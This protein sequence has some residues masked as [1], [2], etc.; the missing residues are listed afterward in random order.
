MPGPQEVLSA[1]IREC[2]QVTP[3]RLVPADRGL[4]PDA[5]EGWAHLLPGG[6]HGRLSLLAAVTFHHVS[7]NTEQA[8]TDPRGA[9]GRA[10][11]P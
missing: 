1:C 4:L 3:A 11:L 10:T 6:R 7:W 5:G 8:N 2:V 9:A